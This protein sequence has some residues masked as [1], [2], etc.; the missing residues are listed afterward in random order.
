MNT[1]FEVEAVI[2]AV[3]TPLPPTTLMIRIT[4]PPQPPRFIRRITMTPRVTMLGSPSTHNSPQL[5]A[6]MRAIFSF[7]F[8]VGWLRD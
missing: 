7:D 6:A 8:A 1:G 3:A 5:P 2:S 4:K